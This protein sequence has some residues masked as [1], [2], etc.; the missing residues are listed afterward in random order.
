MERVRRITH[1]TL[2]RHKNLLVLNVLLDSTRFD[3][4]GTAD[5]G[6]LNTD[7]RQ[8]LNRLRALPQTMFVMPWQTGLWCTIPCLLYLPACYLFNSCVTVSVFN[9][10]PSSVTY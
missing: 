3:S 2:V 1:P 8:G 10:C 9:L 7:P 5:S 4:S 6:V